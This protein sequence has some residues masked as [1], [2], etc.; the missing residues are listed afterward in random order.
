MLIYARPAAVREETATRPIFTNV[1]FACM[2]AI[3]A[4]GSVCTLAK[5]CRQ[6]QSDSKKHPQK[7]ILDGHLGSWLVLGR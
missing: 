2:R 6:T 7:E 5:D 4:A 3:W 1:S